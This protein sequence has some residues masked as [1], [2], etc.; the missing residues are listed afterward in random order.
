MQT[1]Q[2][3]NQT[4]VLQQTRTSRNSRQH[5]QTNR[6]LILCKSKQ[7]CVSMATGVCVVLSLCAGFCFAFNLDTSFPVL[8][9]GEG[10]SL[11]GFSVTL[12]KDMKTGSHLL[13]IGAPRDWAE[14]NVPANRTGGVYSCPI[15]AD[16]LDCTRMKVVN[17]NLNPSKNLV[18][19]MWLG[20]SVASQGGPS[21]RVLVSSLMSLSECSLTNNL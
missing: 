2:S 20:V 18:E 7:V 19:D 16:H 3:G 17:P 12:H 10:G 14:P 11:F 4:D 15:T 8:K 9:R 13:L 5:L 21:G 6:N 1:G